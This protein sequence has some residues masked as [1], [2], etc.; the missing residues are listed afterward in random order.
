MKNIKIANRLEASE[1]ALGCMRITGLKGTDEVRELVD[2]AM[3]QG[4]N[5]LIM[6]TF[7]EMVSQ[8]IFL[9][10]P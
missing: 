2:T 1:I 8:N 6:L 9:E 10:R 7:M 5:F 4:I 3:D